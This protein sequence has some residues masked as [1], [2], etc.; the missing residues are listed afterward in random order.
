[1]H[2]EFDNGKAPLKIR[3][4]KCRLLRKKIQ[5]QLSREDMGSWKAALNQS[6]GMEFGSERKHGRT[7][8]KDL[9]AQSISIHSFGADERPVWSFKHLQGDGIVIQDN[10]VGEDIGLIEIDQKPCTMQAHFEVEMWH[11][12]LTN[13]E[14]LISF[15]PVKAQKAAVSQLVKAYVKDQLKLCNGT[16]KL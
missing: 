14:K 13:F 9:S 5:E 4:E 11:I 6:P 3:D 15:I 16:A 1:M 10:L 8:T 7:L 12:A 2:L